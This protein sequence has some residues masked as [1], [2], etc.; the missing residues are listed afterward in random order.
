MLPEFPQPSSGFSQS[1]EQIPGLLCLSPNQSWET[2]SHKRSPGPSKTGFALNKGLTMQ[3]TGLCVVPRPPRQPAT[4]R[5]GSGGLVV[6]ALSSGCS[7]AGPGRC[8]RPAGEGGVGP[9]RWE[10]CKTPSSQLAGVQMVAV[11][12]GLGETTGG[13]ASAEWLPF[14]P[15]FPLLPCLVSPAGAHSQAA[16]HWRTDAGVLSTDR[17]SRLWQAAAQQWGQRGCRGDS[18]R[19][20]Q[21]QTLLCPGREHGASSPSCGFSVAGISPSDGG[22][23]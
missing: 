15:P 11:L 14:P 1:A 18:A 17:W 10:I 19:G 3:S 7:A 2:T 20:T 6:A 12:T 9:I 5:P 22:G 23:N 21:A 8:H 13:P 4:I 16:S